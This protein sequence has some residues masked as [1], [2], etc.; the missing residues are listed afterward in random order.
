M[1]LRRLAAAAAHVLARSL[2]AG[3]PSTAAGSGLAGRPSTAAGSGLAAGATAPAG[4]TA[5]TAATAGARAP[6]AARARATLFG[7]TVAFATAPAGAAAM[8]AT[9]AT[10]STASATST[11]ASATAPATPSAAVRALRRAVRTALAAYRAGRLDL[12]LARLARKDVALIDPDLDA[13][14]AV[15]R[16]GLRET[17]VDV[18]AQ[19][20]QRD[21]ALAVLLAPRHLCA[22]QPAGAHD[23]DSPHARLYRPQHRLAH[24][25]L[26]GG[27]LLDLLGYR[28]GD[29][30][31]V[32][33]RVADL[34]HADVNLLL[35]QPLQRR[36]QVVYALAAAPDDD[37][38]LGGVQ[39]D[40]DPVARALDLHARD[41]GGSM[42][43]LD[44]A[45]DLI[46]FIEG[47]GEA[48]VRHVPFAFPVPDNAD[49]KPDG[50]DFLSQS[51]LPS[52]FLA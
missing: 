9:A 36:A 31:R 13:D 47:V 10:T 41:G 23:A 11:T 6:L 51:V 5:A 8:T 43:L 14:V 16:R 29:E 37:P 26:V 35:G 24:R 32:H 50:V 20:L 19:G 25:P 38:R 3:R 40:L 34:L 1:A 4:P 52:L 42:V 2:L 39:R 44:V 18:G 15:G 49:A 30:L 12:G 7:A 28:F 22:C 17:V 27:T 21:L 46:V 45:P 48:A 33:V